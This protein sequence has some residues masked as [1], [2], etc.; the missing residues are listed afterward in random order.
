MDKVTQESVTELLQSDAHPAVTIYI[1]MVN[2]A[3][4]PHISENQIRFKN[5]VHRAQEK[6]AGSEDGK[7]LSKDL[8]HLLTCYYD[9]MD[10]WK[11]QSRALLI[12][13]APDM[14]RLFKLPV[15][16][17]EYVAVD[18]A[19]H[20][21]PVLALLSDDRRFYV[22]ALAQQHSRLYRG[23][24]HGLELM[25]IGLPASLREAL[26]IDELNQQSENQGSATG[27]SMSTGWFNGRGGARNPQENDRIRLWHLLDKRLNDRAD[28]SLPLLL[29][30]IDA[31]NAEFR[32]ISRYRHLMKAAIPGNHTETR[33]EELHARAWELVHHELVQPEHAAALEEYIRLTGANPERVA[34]DTDTIQSAAE[35]GRIAKLLTMMSRQTTD[36]VRDKVAPS[37]LISF[38]SGDH[39]RLV[40]NLASKVWQMSGKVIS[41]LPQEMPY[42]APMVARL[43][44]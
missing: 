26:G 43:R 29:A 14:V 6:L 10:F 31:E 19:F 9:D 27:S 37:Y 38:P 12:T 44:Y 40:N 21:A 30:G 36:T 41:L 28:R 15:D 39:S 7:K 22:L 34:R 11:S 18:E 42:G 16:S 32:A 24:M 2:S 3:A 5:M 33:P 17:E 4:P 35:Q 13:A 23:D 8:S 20:L 25:D 1:P